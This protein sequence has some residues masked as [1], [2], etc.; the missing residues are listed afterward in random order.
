VRVLDAEGSGTTDQVAAGIRFAADQGADV[1]NLSFGFLSGVGE[2]VNLI[3]DLDPVNEAVD[4]AGSKEAVVIAAAGNDAFPLCGQPA[5]IRT[6]C[7]WA[8]PTAGTSNPGSRTSMP[9]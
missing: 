9:R 7:A 6:W 1:I 5:R 4:N 3:G 8:L 2:V